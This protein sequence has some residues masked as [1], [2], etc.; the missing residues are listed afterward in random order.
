MASSPTNPQSPVSWPQTM[1][2]TYLGWAGRPVG[3]AW[4]E[5]W[6][7]GPCWW[8]PST[9]SSSAIGGTKAPS[10][11]RPCSAKQ[12]GA[13]VTLVTLRETL[14]RGDALQVCQPLALELGP[15]ATSSGSVER[16]TPGRCRM[17]PGLHG[18]EA[19]DEVN[20]RGGRPRARDLL[21][22]GGPG[23][24]ARPVLRSGASSCGP[25]PRTDLARERIRSPP[26]ALLSAPDGS[27]RSRQ[28]TTAGDGV[29][30]FRLS[31][32]ALPL[33]RCPP[34]GRA[35]PGS[36]RACPGASPIH[37]VYNS[38]CRSAQA[39]PALLAS[40]LIILC[41][42]DGRSLSSRP[43]PGRAR[44]PGLGN[45]WPRSLPPEEAAPAAVGSAAWGRKGAPGAAS[46]PAAA[47]G[48]E[49]LGPAGAAAQPG[50]A[51]QYALEP[52][53]CGMRG[54][55]QG[56]S[57][58]AEPVVQQCLEAMARLRPQGGWTSPAGAPGIAR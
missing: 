55:D 19:V 49:A 47:G 38:P 14:S 18:R 12:P 42:P 27:D 56:A 58:M 3:R 16:A 30:R 17:A 21:D 24:A 29:Q 2:A 26:G 35:G 28:R 7:G 5:P 34:T 20:R 13:G 45:R 22:Q 46:G 53:P 6:P 57:Q 9:P 32:W 1:P 31:D 43:P 40:D 10:S 33:G 15:G 52:L 25:A 36:A 39:V 4:P 37:L 8:P 41:G 51:L 48:P 54:P 50:A 44:L 11:S 23:A